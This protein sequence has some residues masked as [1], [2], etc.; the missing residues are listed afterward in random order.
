[1]PFKFYF[2]NTPTNNEPK[3]NKKIPTPPL[4]RK[5]HNK[6]TR[7]KPTKRPHTKKQKSPTK[8]WFL[9]ATGM[10]EVTQPEWN[11]DTT[12]GSVCFAL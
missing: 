2:K 9:L 7:N 6:Q 10:S 1:M 5:N 8:S 12:Q 3:T 4:K 11:S